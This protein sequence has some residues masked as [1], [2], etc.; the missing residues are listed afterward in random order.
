MIWGDEPVGVVVVYAAWHH[1]FCWLIVIFLFLSLYLG[2]FSVGMAYFA[3]LKMVAGSSC[4]V[5]FPV[6][7]STQHQISDD[8]NVTAHDGSHFKQ[9]ALIMTPFIIFKPRWTEART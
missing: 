5:L 3:T 2:P 9:R 6:Y 7:Q 1:Y 8:S 4:K